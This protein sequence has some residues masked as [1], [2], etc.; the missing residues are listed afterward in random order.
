[1]ILESG[2]S[3]NC[4]RTIQPVF[5][6]FGCSTSVA[7]ASWIASCTFACFRNWT[8]ALVFGS[9]S[10]FPKYNRREPSPW[11]S[12]S[13]IAWSAF[14]AIACAVMAPKSRPSFTP[15]S[16]RARASFPTASRSL[17]VAF[18]L[19]ARNPSF[20]KRAT[21]S[22]TT[23]CK[24]VRIS[25][26]TSGA[27]TGIRSICRS[28]WYGTTSGSYSVRIST[29]VMPRFPHT[30][31][32]FSA[33]EPVARRRAVLLDERLGRGE[34]ED[35]TAPLPEDLRDHDRSD[36]RLAHARRQDH[37][38]RSLEARAGDVHLVRALLHRL[39]TEEL[40]RNEH[41]RRTTPAPK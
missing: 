21:C 18:A 30:S 39:A 5:A 41:G 28:C 36:D 13:S 35:P 31:R 3:M 6:S 26:E 25:L 40:V 20:F 32:I 33:E 1:M 34:E 37:E 9:F 10:M 14:I 2:F 11:V 4:L 15:E 16:R 19:P 17:R 22:S 7:S 24:S 8:S 23:V 27:S 12:A 29:A 38:R